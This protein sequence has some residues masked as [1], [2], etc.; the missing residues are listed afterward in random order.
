M[1]VANASLYDGSSALAEGV[2]MAVRTTKRRKILI[3]QSVHPEYRRVLET[4]TAN[5]DIQIEDLPFTE[6]GCICLESLEQLLSEDHAAVVTQSPNF[7]GVLDEVEAASRLCERAGALSIVVVTEALSMGL[8]KP[9]GELGADIVVGEGQ[10]LGIPLGFGGPYLGL[11][12]TKD[13]YKRQMPGRLVGQTVDSLGRPGFVLTL[14]TREQHIRRQKAT[15]NI[16][17]NQGLCAL[18]AAVFPHHSG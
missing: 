2:L 12:A 4:Y 16:C 6:S 5:L 9:A 7:F 3:P 14:A 15:S 17:T 10:S 11:F 1:E 8:L 18:I 13:K